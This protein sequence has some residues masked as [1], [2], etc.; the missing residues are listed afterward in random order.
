M[1][2]FDLEQLKRDNGRCL[3]DGK[4]A[5]AHAMP[6]A[7]IAVQ[8]QKQHGTIFNAFVR[9]DDPLLRNLPR[10]HLVQLWEHVSGKKHVCMADE[11]GCPSGYA[12]WT[13]VAQREIEEGEGL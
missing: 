2:G 3:Y 11:P 6:E 10:K 9:P 8:Y 4:P 5:Y 12:Y 1:S 7:I 13:L